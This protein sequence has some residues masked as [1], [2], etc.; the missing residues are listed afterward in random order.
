MLWRLKRV[1]EMF[2]DD[3]PEIWDD[4]WPLFYETVLSD[5]EDDES[6]DEYQ[7]EDEQ[8]GG[9]SFERSYSDYNDGNDQSDESFGRLDSSWPSFDD[10]DDAPESLYDD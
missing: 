7:Y 6:T 9:S 8:Y 5:D 3:L 1:V 4:E 10:S 2:L